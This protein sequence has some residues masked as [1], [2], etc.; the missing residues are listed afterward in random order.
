M[1]FKIAKNEL[2]NLFYSPIAWVLVVIFF[3]QCA[4][5]YSSMLESFARQQSAFLRLD[6]NWTGFNR[7]LTYDIFFLYKDAV[8]N[9][10]GQNLYLFIPLLTMGLISREFNKG[11]LTLLNSSPLKLWQLVFG[12]FLATVCFGLLLIGILGFIFFIAGFNI[13]HIDYGMLLASALGFL[14]L[15]CAYASIGL[16]MSSLTS[17][18]IVSVLA[19]FIMLFILSRIGEMWQEKDFIR[20]LT[21]FLSMQGHTAK[22]NQGLITTKDIA[23]Y[24]IIMGMFLSFTLLRL[25]RTR[26]VNEH[27]LKSG[28]RYITVIMVG[29]ALGYVSSRPALVG[30]WDTSA[31]KINTIDPEVQ[32]SLKKLDKGKLKVTLYVNM[33]DLMDAMHGIPE[34]RNKYLTEYWEKYQRFKPDIEY[35]YVYYY[36]ADTTYDNYNL[37]PFKTNLKASARYVADFA[38]R[39]KMDSTIIKTPIEIRKTMDLRPEGNHILMHLEYN[40]RSAILRTFAKQPIWAP[41]NLLMVAINKLVDGFNPKLAY[42]SSGLQRSIYKNGE[43]EY[44]DHSRKK[45]EM[46]ALVNLGFTSDSIDLSIQDIPKGLAALI[47]ADPK[48]KFTVAELQKLSDYVDSGG[49]MMIMGEPGKQDILNPFLQ[50]L[51]VQLLPGQLVQPS[52]DETADNLSVN[53]H[54]EKMEHDHHSHGR[55]M[56]QFKRATALSYTDTTSFSVMTLASTI[57]GQSWLTQAPVVFDSIPPAFDPNGGDIDKSLPTLLMLTRKLGNRQQRIMIAGDTDFLNNKLWSRNVGLMKTLFHG[58]TDGRNNIH[59]HSPDPVDT[60]LNIT[61]A[62]ARFQKMIL[63]YL[64]PAVIFLFGTVLLIRRSRR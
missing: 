48:V 52:K 29:L 31:L 32:A 16:F 4:I 17:N 6:A 42:V 33:S 7:P 14:L 50:K 43:R 64:I 39:I 58:M 46:E 15:I 56:A 40:G 20:D 8:F 54:G 49:N 59:I 41:D 13:Q 25:Y 1:I 2:R 53:I 60:R 12:K 5:V 22:F 21:Y 37:K 26:G 57:A 27:W 36:D 38:K 3:G 23:Y 34:S 9:Q 35:H 51:G 47:I 61:L 30:Y 55:Q 10:V 28:S 44:S 19:T 11:T 24:L 63:V 45:S 18:Y 62:E